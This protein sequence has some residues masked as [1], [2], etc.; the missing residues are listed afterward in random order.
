M[1]STPRALNRILLGFCGLVLML[2][3]TCGAALAYVPGS[4][5]PWQEFTLQAGLQADRIRQGTTLD[6]QEDSWLWIVL[7]AALL[8]VAVL[9]T[10]WI[11]AQGRG[12]TG[13]FAYTPGPAGSD[14]AGAAGS[15]TLT[16]G[17]A[18]QALR[19]ALLEGNDLVNAVVTTWDFHGGPALRVRLFPRKG[20]SPYAIAAVTTELIEALD[21]VAGRRTP[22]LISISS[23]ARSRFTRPERVS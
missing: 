19:A 8:L 16:A 23:G 17:A 9:G 15:V 22:V 5:G 20:V 18:E 1:N 14:A 3:G 10:A 13:V 12:R 6:G 11:A 7:A 2:A 4:A 21:L